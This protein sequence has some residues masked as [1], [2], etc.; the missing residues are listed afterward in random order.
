MTKV[1]GIIYLRAPTLWVLR[2]WAFKLPVILK[3]K[4]NKTKQNK[5]TKINTK[6]MLAF[7]GKAFHQNEVYVKPTLH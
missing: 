6:S 4:T 3:N 5:K 7:K 2:V 1:S